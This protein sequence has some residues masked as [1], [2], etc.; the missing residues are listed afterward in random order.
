M[1]ETITDYN[2][3]WL[4]IFTFLTIVAV[5]IGIVL[6]KGKDTFLFTN[7]FNKHTAE[8][9]DTTDK[10]SKAHT[11]VIEH[12]PPVYEKELHALEK[13]NKKIMDILEDISDKLNMLI[14]HLAYNKK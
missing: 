11:E 12:L 10:F 3:F 14:E 4:I 8:H 6:L 9:I 7:I 1:I 13:N 2:S 5:I